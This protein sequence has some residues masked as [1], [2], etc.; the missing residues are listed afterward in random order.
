MI[1]LQA[2]FFALLILHLN[3][4]A[5]VV[6]NETM[7]EKLSGGVADRRHDSYPV[8]GNWSLDGK[9]SLDVVKPNQ[10]VTTHYVS[11]PGN[12]WLSGIDHHGWARY[13]RDFQ[14]LRKGHF[15]RYWLQLD[16]VDY[17]SQV[18]LNNEVL[19]EEQGYFIPRIYDVTPIITK[20]NNSL[21]VW[22]NSPNEPSEKTPEWSLHKH[23]IKGVLNHHDTRPG[24]AWSK[25]GQDR[26]SGGIWGSVRVRETGPVAVTELHVQPQVVD[27]SNQITFAR[28]DI[29]LDANIA[30]TVR[31]TVMLTSQQNEY[32]EIYHFSRHLQ[33]GRQT[34]TFTFPELQ[35]EL[36]WP[37]DWGHPNL[38]DFAVVVE[39]NGIRSDTKTAR[40][41][42]R[43][44]KLDETE[45]QFYI[46]DRPY[47]IRGTNYIASQ[48]LGVM[49]AADYRRD[50]MLMQKANI[51]GIRVH[52]HV[53]GQAFYE[54]A[55]TMGFLVWQD[56]PLQWGYQDNAPFAKEAARQAGV[57]TDILFNHPSIV[58]WCGH[59]EPPWDASWMQYKYDT[60]QPELNQLLTETVYREL[61]SANDGRIVRKASYTH[62]HPWLGW[63]SG[64]YTDYANFKSPM[65]VSEFGAQAM[66]SWTLLYQIL[67]QQPG[68]SHQWP[69]TDAS[70]NILAYHNYQ[71]HE[72]LDIADVQQGESLSQFWINSQEYQRVVTKFAAEHLRLRKGN[73]IAAIYQFMFVDSWPAITWSV[74]DVNRQAKPGYDA[75]RQAYQ[76]V[77]AIASLDLGRVEPAL[78][79]TIVNDYRNS[80]DDVT[81]RISNRYNNKEWLFKGIEIPANGK[82]AVPFV[83]PLYGISSHIFLELINQEGKRIS[84]NYYSARDL[85][86]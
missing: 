82:V 31:L 29:E 5:I 42:F 21:S 16:A 1:I 45:R 19:G 65:I 79:V 33:A 46:N 10:S 12:W 67:E 11:V 27:V 30:Q 3:A 66:P 84:E 78:N 75:L 58:I 48:W 85:I 54:L 68:V 53:A 86:R 32:Q 9:W 20:G 74:L 8:G 40:I 50:L 14:L 57:M 15:S 2:I 38:Y 80:F 60:Y 4:C 52:A 7:K 36:W 24:G 51:N 59:N 61:L 56:F 76:P 64:H 71:Q 55:D 69:L 44:V 81:L 35:R 26:N 77:L 73:G 62:E 83:E 47:F 6:K 39:T 63:Y 37:W 43:K 18:V 17:A 23:L 34:V 25:R 28:A 49:S 22:V 70:L 13:Y 41:G 72:T